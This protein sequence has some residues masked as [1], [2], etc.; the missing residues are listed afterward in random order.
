VLIKYE[1]T[2]F[3]TTTNNNNKKKRKIEIII[4]YN[5]IKNT[6]KKHNNIQVESEYKDYA[7]NHEDMF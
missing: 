4:P 1:R 5:Q 2:Y 3:Y 7:P 6:Y